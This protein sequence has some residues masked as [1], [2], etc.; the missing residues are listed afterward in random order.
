MID[1]SQLD[2][3]K[4][5]DGNN[6]LGFYTFYYEMLVKWL[7]EPVRYNVLL[8]FKKDCGYGH[9]DVLARCL[10]HKIAS[11]ATLAGVHTIDSAETPLAQLADLLT[12]AVA[13]SW[14][15]LE[16]GKPKAELAEHIAASAGMS[17]LKAYSLSPQFEKLNI[18]KISLR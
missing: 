9:K 6:E 11:G 4:Y 13:A 8:D 12:G 3:E 16:A 5:K 7:Q 15:G 2:F 14:C 18:F 1:Q 10:R 17:G